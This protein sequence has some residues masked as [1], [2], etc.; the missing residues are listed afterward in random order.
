V[1][2][3]QVI[4]CVGERRSESLERSQAPR[5]AQGEGSGEGA[6]LYFLAF[7]NLF[8]CVCGGGQRYSR[9]KYFVLGLES[10]PM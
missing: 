1:T 3:I 5:S 7:V 8:V 2:S 10:T 9:P 4:S 6:N